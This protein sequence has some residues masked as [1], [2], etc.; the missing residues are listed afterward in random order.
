MTISLIFICSFLTSFC[1]AFIYDAPRRLFLPAGLCGGFGYLTYH[2]VHMSFGIDSIYASL[3]G[4][5]ILGIM[6]HMMA[7]RY[8]S[9]VILFMVPGIIPLVPGSIFFKAAQ[10]LLTLEFNEANDIFIRATLIAGAIAVGLLM[11]DQFAK[12]FIRKPIP[13]IRPKRQHKVRS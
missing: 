11:S 12:S 13:I 6:S 8:K 1:F 5:F 7:R 2:L 10:K 4:S 9:P 3:C